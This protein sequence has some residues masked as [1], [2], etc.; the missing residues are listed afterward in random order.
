MGG[1]CGRMRARSRAT[2][3]VGGGASRATDEGPRESGGDGGLREAPNFKIEGPIDNL[4]LGIEVPVMF[5]GGCFDVRAF[6]SPNSIPGISNPSKNH[7]LS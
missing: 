1:Q 3:A 6:F 2:H 4:G 5:E 7:Q